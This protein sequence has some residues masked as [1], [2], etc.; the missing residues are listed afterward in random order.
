[1]ICNKEHRFLSDFASELRHSQKDSHGE[2]HKC[3]GCAFLIGLQDALGGQ[4]KRTELPDSL[5]ES[6]AGMIRHRDAWQAYE[7]GYEQGIVFNS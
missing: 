3:P 4:K 7:Q 2:R 1:M 5:P 6:Q